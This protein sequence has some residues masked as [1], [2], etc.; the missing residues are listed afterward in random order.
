MNVELT[1]V[2]LLQERD[3]FLRS[4]V[5]KAGVDIFMAL[6][7]N[8]E[9]FLIP[10]KRRKSSVHGVLCHGVF[11]ILNTEK[12]GPTNR[13]GLVLDSGATLV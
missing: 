5:N 1:L 9:S 3:A 2:S 11:I 13:Q 12:L 4:M 7:R 6:N 10:S 8:Q